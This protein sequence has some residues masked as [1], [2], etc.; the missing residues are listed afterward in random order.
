MMSVGTPRSI[1][2]AGVG[3]EVRGFAGPVPVFVLVVD[4]C[5][6]EEELRAVKN[7]LLL[8]VEQ[9]PENALVGLI[10]FDAMV[11][12][13]DLGFSDCSRVVVFHGGREV[14]SEQVLGSNIQL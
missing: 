9:L 10:T 11:R 3:G 14:S 1:G 7:E 12:V 8:V 2:G 6:V 4:A 5:M 13:Y